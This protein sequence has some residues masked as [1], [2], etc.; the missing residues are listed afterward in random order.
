MGDILVDACVFINAMKSDS[1]HRDECVAFLEMLSQSNQPMLMPAHG[2]FEVWCN[3]KRIEKIDKKFQ[4]AAIN[5]LWS[6]PIRLIHIDDKFI[7]KYGNMEIPYSKAGDHIYLVVALGEG[8]RLV[9]TDNGMS[10][11]ARQL[12]IAVFTPA[13][14]VATQ[15]V[16]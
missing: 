15:H 11:I 10:K 2:W 8:Y 6:F 4:G 9:T 14:F 16:A 7:S 13:E 5:S 3:L 12:E 1:V